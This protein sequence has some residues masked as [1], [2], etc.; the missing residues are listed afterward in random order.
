VNT[1][2]DSAGLDGR[3]RSRRR[4]HSAEF[5]AHVIAACQHPGV[6]I[7][8]VALANGLNANM[9]RRW[10]H[11]AER[12]DTPDGKRAVTTVDIA[13][14]AAPA[15]VQLPMPVAPA[16]PMPAPKPE[17]APASIFVEIQRANTSVYV[18]WPTSAA[19]DAT[20]WLRELLR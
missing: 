7:A 18:T 9:L 12:G 11:D 1:S 20:V 5:K 19:A 16:P 2:A 14:P 6:S 10:L 15:F 4:R 13:T 3:H 17:P 8:S